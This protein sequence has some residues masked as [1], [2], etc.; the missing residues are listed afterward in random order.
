[1]KTQQD[2]AQKWEDVVFENRNRE[3]GAYALRQDYSQNMVRSF[4]MS[5]GFGIALLIFFISTKQD[6]II[7][8]IKP[9]DPVI[10][11]DDIKDIKIIPEK[12]I[13]KPVVKTV[14]TSPHYQAVIHE[15]IEK[16]VVE[17]VDTQ[18]VVDG[19][20]DGAM[21]V[22]ST[23]VGTIDVGEVPIVNA[24]PKVFLVVEEMPYFDGLSKFLQKKLRYPNR[25]ERNR[26]EGTVF[27]KFI[28]NAAG[29][30]TKVELLK[31][32]D[33]D[34]DKEA[35]RVISAMPTWKPGIQNKMAVSVQ[36]VLPIK[37]K[38]ND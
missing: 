28:I 27:V 36:M 14:S 30:V 32:I 26:V 13:A 9:I 12:T 8:K 17:Q 3:Y 16:P 38:L 11:L 22:G 18:P 15:V 10:E 31:G 25:A 37:F 29:D 1:M 34:C 19:V 6:G 5:L 20:D 7:A 23:D 21:Q 33:P 35:M 4:L 2:T 24:E